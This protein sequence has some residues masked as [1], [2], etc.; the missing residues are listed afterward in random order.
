MPR[1]SVRQSIIRIDP[2]I[3]DINQAL[4]FA[5]IF[6]GTMAHSILSLNTISRSND[7][8][9]IGFEPPHRLADFSLP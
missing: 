1:L 4:A 8:S 3:S 7:I 9:S 6:V 2:A 5:R